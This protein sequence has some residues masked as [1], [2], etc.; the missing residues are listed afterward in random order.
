MHSLVATFKGQTEGRTQ[1]YS[2]FYFSE[3]NY[4]FMSS[5]ITGTGK[6]KQIKATVLSHY[7]GTHCLP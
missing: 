6:F 3:A 4:C 7:Q 1:L 5:S 2:D